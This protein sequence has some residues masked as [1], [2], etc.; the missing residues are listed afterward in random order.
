[1]SLAIYAA[2]FNENS[3]YKE[4]NNDNVLNKKKQTHHNKTQKRYIK[5]DFDTL[6][7]NDVLDN[8]HNNQEEDDYN[9]L[10]EFKPPPY[11][12]SSGV[13]KT[14]DAKEINNDVNNIKNVIG[15]APQSINNNET[16][17]D[18][19]NYKL[20]Y[21][22][23][24]SNDEYY[25]KMMPGYIRNQVNRQHNNINIPDNLSPSDQDVLLHK[26]NYMINLLEDQQDEK[27]NNVTEEVILYSFLGIF[28]I[29]IVDSFARIGK[30]VR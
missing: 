19:N 20:N 25:N 27:T 14:I 9:N 10:G 12:N 5:E 2:P 11:P 22:N 8:I 30:Y 4:E 17:L 13:N 1:M 6:K 15:V 26:I 3:M 16:N 7:V 18:L 23:K 21:G 29:F 24:H 28:M